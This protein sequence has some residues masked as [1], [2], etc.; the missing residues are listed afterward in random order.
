M[1]KVVAN[2]SERESELVAVYVIPELRRSGP[3]NGAERDFQLFPQSIFE[4]FQIVVSGGLN[5][6]L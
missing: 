6:T 4:G 1:D 2:Y 5:A 3:N